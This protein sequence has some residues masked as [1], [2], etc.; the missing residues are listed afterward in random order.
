M[1]TEGLNLSETEELVKRIQGRLKR[2]FKTAE[3]DDP[4]SRKMITG[5]M[6]GFEAYHEK[7]R[8]FRQRSKEKTPDFLWACYENPLLTKEQEYHLFRRYNYH[9]FLAQNWLE[10]NQLV[11]A[12]AEL[13]KS[14]EIRKMI[15]ASNVRLGMPS[16]KRYKHFRHYEDL[17][18]ES[19]F[20][21]H[22]AVDYFDYS[23]N[24]KFSTYATWAVVNTMGNKAKEL[25][26]HDAH[27][28]GEIENVSKGLVAGKTESEENYKVEQFGEITQVLLSCVNPRERK[29]L[30]LRFFNDRTL[31]SIADDMGVSK[32]RIRQ[33]E[34]VAL[35]KIAA[36]VQELG[37]KEESIW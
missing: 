26:D 22:R 18:A 20:I 4:N 6:P 34:T 7:C 35:K 29:I 24:L 30:E 33:I 31:Q 37:L 5:V 2:V 14:D 27:H 36:K 19:F 11:K 1:K 10:L 16:V 3:F 32:E 15:S 13:R 25:F 23:R 28:S 17:I 9:K 8:Q 12:S 21:I